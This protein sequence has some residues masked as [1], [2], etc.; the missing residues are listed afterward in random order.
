LFRFGI[1]STIDAAD[2]RNI[3]FTFSFD[4][5]YDPRARVDRR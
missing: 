2:E 1:A 3:L 4:P 5:V